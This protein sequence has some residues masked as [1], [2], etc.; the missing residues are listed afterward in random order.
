MDYRLSKIINIVRDLNEEM[1]VANAAGSSGGFGQNS[2]AA[3]PT[4]GYDKVQGLVRRKNKKILGAGNFKGARGRFEKGVKL[5]A[6]LKK[7]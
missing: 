6:K 5:L 3:G 7:K 2:A 1:M 4:A